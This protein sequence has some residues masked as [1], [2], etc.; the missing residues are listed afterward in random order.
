MKLYSLLFLSFMVFLVSCTKDNTETTTGSKMEDSLLHVEAE[1]RYA[2]Q[3]DSA[4]FHIK[5]YR[6][7]VKASSKEA[8]DAV[9]SS[10]GD[11][12]TSEANRIKKYKN[13]ISRSGDSLII[14]TVNGG[15][16][17]LVTKQSDN[18]DL[19]IYDFIQDMP[20]INQWLVLGSYWESYGY[21]LI[22]KT[23][24]ETTHLY[25]MPV[26]SP[27]KKHIIAFNQDLQAGFTFNG[28]QLLEMQNGKPVL[29]GEKELYYWGPDN[30]SWK[31]DHTLLVQQAFS[32]LTEGEQ[33]M[34]TVY[35][36]LEMDQ[37]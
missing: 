33:D 18:D 12:D 20:D 9:K 32:N 6:F 22:D 7:E 4:I 24:G 14:K 8:F 34:T 16:V 11:M 3:V 37:E 10:F 27:D 21:L 30:V 23:S 31:N 28:L 35:V 2:E 19:A 36:E 26:V 5:N 17:Y 25:G 1:D 15:N 13:L 29:I